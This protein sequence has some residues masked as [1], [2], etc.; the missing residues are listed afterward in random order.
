MNDNII[1]QKATKYYAVRR[2]RNPGVYTDVNEYRAQVDGFEGYLARVFKNEQE[3]KDY[4]S[5]KIT[6]TEIREAK[7]RDLR[8]IACTLSAKNQNDWD[9][10][11]R[12]AQTVAAYVDGSHNDETNKCGYGVVITTGDGREILL[13]GVSKEASKTGLR[14]TA[15]EI[16]GCMAA[17]EWAKQKHVKKL[18]L[19]CDCSSVIELA[20]KGGRPNNEFMRKFVYFYKDIV[21]DGKIE[22]EFKKIAGHVG[23]EYGDLSDALARYA[24]GKTIKS[25]H[26]QII[27]NII[28][29]NWEANRPKEKKEKPKQKLRKEFYD[30][31][32][33]RASIYMV[34]IIRNAVVLGRVLAVQRDGAHITHLTAT[35]KGEFFTIK[36]EDFGKKV[37][38]HRENAERKRYELN[39]SEQFN[40]TR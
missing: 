38:M 29:I 25:T 37:F 32:H 5:G 21:R 27:N 19:I 40:G 20:M 9:L 11:W 23:N 28:P 2:G 8:G 3:A 26:K 33:P 22:I 24:L 7:S 34:D 17:I 36:R 30:N 12:A 31:W 35:F 6:D 16:S 14:S 15:A 39:G 1:K 4:V 18:I 13:Y 10:K